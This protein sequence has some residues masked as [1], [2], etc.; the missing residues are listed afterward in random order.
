MSGKYLEKIQL[1]IKFTNSY[2]SSKE[3]ISR[4]EKS[5][6]LVEN[7]L[8]K[9]LVTIFGGYIFTFKISQ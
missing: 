9:K 3:V 6:T 4:L 2:G 5:S 1:G 8:L 7:Q